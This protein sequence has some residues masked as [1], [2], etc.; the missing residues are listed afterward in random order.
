VSLSVIDLL[1]RRVSVLASGT[2]P[3]GH[4]EVSFVASGLPSGVYLYRLE[5]GDFVETRRMV[6]VK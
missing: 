1:G 5:A 6:I 4:Y 2:Q 3:A